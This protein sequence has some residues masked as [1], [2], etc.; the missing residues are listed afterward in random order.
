MPQP[1]D[2]NHNKQNLSPQVDRP[3]LTQ[4]ES[5]PKSGF[6]Q[7]F[8]LGSLFTLMVGFGVCMMIL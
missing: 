7:G 5:V 6:W 8:F 4:S 1:N 2:L 3:L